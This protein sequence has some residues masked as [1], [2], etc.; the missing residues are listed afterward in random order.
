MLYAQCQF[1]S[2]FVLNSATLHKNKARKYLNLQKQLQTKIKL[3]AATSD[4]GQHSPPAS[5]Q[6][7]QTYDH[8]AICCED[9]DREMYLGKISVCIMV[10]FI[11]CHSIRWIPNIY[12]LFQHVISK[13][14]YWPTWVESTTHLSHFMT[15]FDSSINFYV[16][17]FKQC[18]SRRKSSESS[19]SR[20]ILTN[21]TNNT[22]D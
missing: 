14:V 21:R 13:T 1:F 18:M 22:F 10:I 9:I 11:I 7:Y 4:V 20:F 5:Y 2:D 17:A 3:G 19:N 6:S 12:E 15:T 8:S 16:Y